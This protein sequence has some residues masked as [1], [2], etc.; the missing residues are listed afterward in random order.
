MC[1]YHNIRFRLHVTSEVLVLRH[2]HLYTRT[3]YYR[4]EAY[5]IFCELPR[6]L[7][8]KIS[9]IIISS[10]TFGRLPNVNSGA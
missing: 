6:Q 3:L 10:Q 8:K 5:E 2:M 1:L 4:A 9:V 7:Y